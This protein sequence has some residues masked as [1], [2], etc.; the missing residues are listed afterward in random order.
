ML[1]GTPQGKQGE[2][3]LKSVFRFILHQN[4]LTYCMLRV[5]D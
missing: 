3:T 5:K 1:Q 4:K 2:G